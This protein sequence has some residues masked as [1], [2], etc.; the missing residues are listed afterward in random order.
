M[1][2]LIFGILFLMVTSCTI[3]NETIYPST[4]NN[5]V[6]TSTW[7]KTVEIF[8]NGIGGVSE[9]IRI[10]EPILGIP[11]DSLVDCSLNNITIIDTIRTNTD[12]IGS[13]IE[14]YN[15]KTFIPN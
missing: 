6:H 14:V 12:G 10:S 7:N 11:Y 9:I 15:Q 8:E 13:Y 3:N 4:C 5:T 2:K 1:K